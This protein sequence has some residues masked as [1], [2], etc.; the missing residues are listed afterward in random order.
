MLI[1]RVDD[2]LVESA[3]WSGR[4]NAPYR[5]AQIHRWLCKSKKIMHMPTL[6]CFTLQNFPDTVKLIQQETLEG[7]MNPQ[8]HGWEHINYNALS[9]FDIKIHLDKSITWFKENLGKEPLIWCTPWGSV[10]EKLEKCAKTFGLEIQ[11]TSGLLEPLLWLKNYE[12]ESSE[13][14]SNLIENNMCYNILAHW[15]ERGGRLDRISKM[16]EGIR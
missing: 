1:I 5:F 13:T 15:W 7:R 16:C 2:V 12:N 9:E 3:Q 11:G 10:S 14:L 6:I 8:L 4:R